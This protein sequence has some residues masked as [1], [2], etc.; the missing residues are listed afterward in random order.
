MSDSNSLMYSL[1]TC[2]A[3]LVFFVAFVV[4]VATRSGVSDGPSQGSEAE[5]DKVAAA[6]TSEQ[7]VE[8]E[9]VDVAGIVSS[10]TAQMQVKCTHCG[11]D[12]PSTDKFCGQCGQVL[13][14]P[15]PTEKSCSRCGA[16]NPAEYLFCV[17]CGTPLDVPHVKPT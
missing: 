14:G 5:G 12:N 17:R 6:R 11:A 10:A 16:N 8:D 13:T 7:L 3:V 1:M 15:A 4:F 9:T 2:T